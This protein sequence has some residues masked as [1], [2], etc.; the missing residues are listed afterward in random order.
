[1]TVT[2]V[3]NQLCVFFGGTYDTVTRTYR[4]PQVVGL[5][6]VRRAFAKRDDHVDYTLGQVTDHG[7]QMVVQLSEGSERRIAA[8]GPTLGLKERRHR[9]DLH[10]FIRST[11]AFAE[12]AQD[13][14]DTLR[15]AILDRIH[16]DRTC[17]SGGFEVGGFQV[18]EGSGVDIDWHLSQA[19]TVVELTKFYLLITTTALENIQA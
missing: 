1:M 14:A 7:C 17:G 4:T 15:E 2:A 9:I 19:S 11:A 10:C 3:R 5:G 12:D 18:G 16:A 13:Y 8:A 6:A